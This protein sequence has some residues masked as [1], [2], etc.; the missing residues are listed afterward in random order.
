[1][2][3]GRDLRRHRYYK[4]SQNAHGKFVF[5]FHFSIVEE[6]LN[7]WRGEMF[8]MVKAPRRK[9]SVSPMAPVAARKDAFG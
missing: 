7:L 5:H 9:K 4:E 8:P 6:L 1:M 2:L 3:G